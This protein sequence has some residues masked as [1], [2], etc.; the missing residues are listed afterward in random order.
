MATQPAAAQPGGKRLKQ[1]ARDH[2][3]PRPRADTLARSGGPR[4]AGLTES[5]TAVFYHAAI[6]A[7]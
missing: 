2:K 4:L 1:D 5:H 7:P 3:R 6:T